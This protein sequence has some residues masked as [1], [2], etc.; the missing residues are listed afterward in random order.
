MCLIVTEVPFRD[1]ACGL[2][3]SKTSPKLP[4]L[5]TPSTMKSQSILALTALASAGFAFGQATTTPVGYTTQTLPANTLSLV[6]FNVLPAAIAVGTITNVTGGSTVITDTAINFDTTLTAGSMY[7]IEINDGPGSIDGAVQEFVTWSG[8]T[9]TVPA[10]T[11]VAIGDK[12]KIRPVANL[13]DVFPV[14]F[15]TGAALASSADKVWVPN[16]SGGYTKYWYRITIAPTGWR[17]TTTGLNDTGAVSSP[18]P[19]PYIDGI[20]IEK[21]GT[22]KDFVQTGELKTTPTSAVAVVGL[23]PLSVVPPAGLTLFTSGLDTQISGAALAS[24]A[25]KIWVPNG[26]GGY[27][28]YWYR[29]TIAPTGWRTTT[30]GLNDTGAVASDVTLP[31]GIM[32]ERKNSAKV[33]NMQVPAG[34]SGL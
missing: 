8:N 10:M 16:G 19:L 13:Q 18:V 34:Y 32:I 25:D 4:H 11:G 3:P 26:L 29:I 28:K 27:T 30:T 21:K 20:L 9:I 15:L 2:S 24:S 23:N 1:D 33:I 14:G 22:A 12:Y 17:T 31:S 7:T 5:S 6:G